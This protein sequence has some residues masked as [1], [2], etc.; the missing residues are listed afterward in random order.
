[1]TRELV[2]SKN[3]W[4]SLVR[5]HAMYLTFASGASR[6]HTWGG[7]AVTLPVRLVDFRCH[8][9]NKTMQELVFMIQSCALETSPSMAAP[10]ERLA[11]RRNIRYVLWKSSSGT[12]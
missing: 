1:M 2:M 4:G 11:D 8:F 3:G 5:A 9:V 7:I 6:G 10:D 12:S